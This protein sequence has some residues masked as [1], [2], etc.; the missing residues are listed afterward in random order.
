MLCLKKYKTKGLNSIVRIF[1]ALEVRKVYC[2]N[3]ISKLVYKEF[4][5]L[6]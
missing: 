1:F 3:I 2:E 5:L 4:M 6:R